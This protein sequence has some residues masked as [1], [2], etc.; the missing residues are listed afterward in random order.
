MRF[1]IVIP[2]LHKRGGTERCVCSLAEALTRRGHKFTVFGSSIADGVLPGAQF[3]RVPMLARPHPARFLSFLID[4]SIRRALESGQRFDL[5]LSTGP[6]VLRP[7]IAIFHSCAASVLESFS[8]EAGASSKRF[9]RLRAL[10]NGLT[11]RI[12]TRLERYVS[13]QGARV[14]VGV[15]GALRNDFI[16]HYGQAAARMQVIPNGVDLDEFNPL[17]EAARSRLRPELGLTTDDRVLIFVGHNWE[18]K[19]LE[20]LVRALETDA[21]REIK[22]LV[23][24][25]DPGST[26]ATQVNRR[27]ANRARFLGTRAD[28]APLYALSD[29]CVL[30]SAL[31]SFGLPILEAMACGTPAAV[32]KSA[33]VAEL[34]TDGVDGLLLDDP[35]DVAEIAA[36][37]AKLFADAEALR[38]MAAR[39]R[40]TAQ[41]YSW[42]KIAERFEALCESALQRRS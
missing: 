19:G 12:V 6:D 10:S 41:E 14:T 4:N 8:K 35:S 32:S 36:K 18:R 38:A 2:E 26:Y 25:G 30:P 9:A 3:R 11:Y 39:A 20:Y 17:P 28:M 7:D 27:L 34:M 13:T 29:A 21:L 24:G 22:L 16:R 23:I 5:L 15:S 31:E 37:V 33:G 40:A 1:A 42:E